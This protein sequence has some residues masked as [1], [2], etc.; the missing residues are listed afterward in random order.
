MP[1]KKNTISLR[2]VAGGTSS[3]YVG[4]VFANFL[5]Q[6]VIFVNPISAGLSDQRLVPGGV[7]RTPKLFSANVD[8]FLDLW[9][10]CWTIYS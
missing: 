4:S 6:L 1:L 9:N 8:L 2:V 7:F 5:K 3:Q 10:H